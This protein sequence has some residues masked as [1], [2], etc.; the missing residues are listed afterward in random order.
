MLNNQQ[1]KKKNNFDRKHLAF[2]IEGVHTELIIQGFV[3]KIFIMITQLNKP[4][5]IMTGKKEDMEGIF[6]IQT[7]VGKREEVIHDIFANQLMNDI[8]KTSNKTLILSVALKEM[9][10]SD[11]RKISKQII[12]IILKHKIW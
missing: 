12:E 1:K 4:G 9:K 8:S 2:L 6:D 10:E 11:N 5:T 3:D 7:L